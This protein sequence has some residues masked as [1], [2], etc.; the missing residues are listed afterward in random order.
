ME[1]LTDIKSIASG[2]SIIR[3]NPIYLLKMTEVDILLAVKVHKDFEG[4][5]FK[6]LD[7]II[8]SPGGNIEAAYQIIKVLRNHCEKLTGIVPFAAKSAA[9]L[10]CLGMDKLILGEIGELGPLDVQI[11]E[12]QDGSAELKSALNGF[13][14][15]EHI[16]KYAVETLDIATKV[17][18][19]RCEVKITE[20][21]SLATAFSAIVA[22]PLYAQINPYKLGEHARDLE[23]SQAYGLR[24]MTRYMKWKKEAADKLLQSIVW[25][26]PSHAFILDV[27]E[28]QKLG[29]P[30]SYPEPGEAEFIESLKFPIN[31]LNKSY[32]GFIIEQVPEPASTS[33]SKENNHGTSAQPITKEHG[34]ANGKQLEGA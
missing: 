17:I 11:P 24:I 4:K 29:L 5:N 2:L 7:V 1:Q 21:I 14:A 32:V 30:A 22:N 26:Y 33:A 16:Q 15:L 34:E 3:Q 13:K 31:A 27:E 19:N 23:I 18:L 6:N 20:A 25:G 8:E 12:K 28:L 10:I 9:T